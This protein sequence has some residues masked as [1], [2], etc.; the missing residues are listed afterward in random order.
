[1]NNTLW[2]VVMMAAAGS[3]AQAG[4]GVPAAARTVKVCS[5][6]VPMSRVS[7]GTAHW[8][9]TD[10]FARIGVKLVW[11]GASHCPAGALQ[12]SLSART[13]AALMP[14]ALAY[15][16]PYEGT[17]V[18]VFLDRV[19]ATVSDDTVGTALLAHVFVH[20]I[21]HILQGYERHS[22]SGIMKAK[23]DT[24]DY[25]IMSSRRLPFAEE[26]IHI[27]Y[28]GIDLRETAVAAA[29]R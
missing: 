29:A 15:A 1:M 21:T 5:D 3:A 18:V 10:I 17:R 16:L 13:P 22:S 4:H 11:H 6:L 2:T 23:W 28:E 24:H 14:G 27:L 26:D 8:L 20:E 19:Q 12:I 9:A 7:V 25:D